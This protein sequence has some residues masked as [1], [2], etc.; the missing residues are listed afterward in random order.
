MESEKDKCEVLSV[1]SKLAKQIQGYP[2]V[3]LHLAITAHKQVR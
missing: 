1:M 3:L 2:K